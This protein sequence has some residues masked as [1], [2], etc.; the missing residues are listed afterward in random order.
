VN[1][2]TRPG[3]VTVRRFLDDEND[4]IIS[5][6]NF[7]P[8]FEAYL[9]HVRRWERE[10]DGLGSVMMR[11]GLAAAGLHL[12]N[13][14]RDEYVG[15]TLNVCSPPLNIFLTGDSAQG[16]VTG[17]VYA[18]NV[19][20]TGA[21]RLFV[22]TRR[23]DGERTESTVEVRGL[24]VLQIFE[25]YYRDSEQQP[26]RLFEVTDNEVLML[27][28]LPDSDEEWLHALARDEAIGL[29]EDDLRALDRKVF[30]FRCGCDPN[31][32]QGVVRGLFGEDPEQLFRG[33][34]GVEVHCPR[35]G[36]RWWVDRADFV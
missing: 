16:A 12:A 9:D 30:R 4:L 15:W 17:R 20:T 18:E 34:P 36:R 26:V 29:A 23:S 11:Q 7:A 8:L 13:R 2:D 25:Q 22:Q 14:P 5:R 6:S 33:E 1:A 19:R 27:L 35:C 28:G 24:D 32:I 3:E 31:T 10:P 21:N